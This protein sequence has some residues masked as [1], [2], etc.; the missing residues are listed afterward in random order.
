MLDEI[1]ALRA[2]LAQFQWSSLPPPFDDGFWLPFGIPS[3]KGGVHIWACRVFVFQGESIFG[4][5]ELVEFRLYLGASHCIY[6][7]SSCHIFVG[8]FMLGGDTFIAFYVSCFDCL[9]IYI[10]ELF[11]D[12]CLYC[13]LF[14]IKN[15]L[16][17]T[18]IFHT[19]GYAFCLV[20]Q[21]IYTLIQLSCCLHLQL[22][23]ST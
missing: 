12:I 13:V 10:Y 5:L 20:F 1:R 16:L 2:E 7:F 22:M 14:E 18:C 19:C 15:L 21:E 8:L 23:D 4:W 3:Q 17:F 6:L 9:L 11:I